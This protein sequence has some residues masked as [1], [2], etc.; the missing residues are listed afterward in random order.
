MSTRAK[1]VEYLLDQIDTVLKLKAETLIKTSFRDVL[2]SLNSEGKFQGKSVDAAVTPENFK[3]EIHLDILSLPDFIQRG[4]VLNQFNYCI[5]EIET[6]QH[7]HSS[8]HFSNAEK[9]SQ[10][11]TG[12]TADQVQ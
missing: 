4:I 8:P 3:A 10:H 1:N 11:N 2:V 5:E 12:E 9:P 7:Q 6:R